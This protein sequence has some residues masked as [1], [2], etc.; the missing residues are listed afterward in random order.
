MHEMAFVA[1]RRVR[2]CLSDGCPQRVEKGPPC[3]EE[4]GGVS[5]L[6]RVGPQIA[7]VYKVVAEKLLR[8]LPLTWS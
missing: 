5:R 6:A 1:D 8:N 4:V 7:H 3:D 2:H